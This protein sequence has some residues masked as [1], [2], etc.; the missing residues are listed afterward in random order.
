MVVR[1][2]TSTVR[3]K[4]G[5]K[6]LTQKQIYP[7]DPR[8]GTV[9]L[10]TIL[11]TQK[12]NFRIIKIGTDK[13]GIEKRGGVKYECEQYSILNEGRQ[14][15]LSSC[16]TTKLQQS[17]VLSLPEINKIT[18]FMSRSKDTVRSSNLCEWKLKMRLS[19]D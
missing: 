11:W 12:G 7:L 9:D 10:W 2:V 8:P 4:S 16:S 6:K 19:R 18:N 5:R 17:L 3:K 15:N 14:V 13:G 1:R